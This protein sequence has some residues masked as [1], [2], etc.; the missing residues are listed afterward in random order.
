MEPGYGD[1]LRQTQGSQD[2]FD[3]IQKFID[4]HRSSAFPAFVMIFWLANGMPMPG[5][6][7]LIACIKTLP[8]INQGLVVWYRSLR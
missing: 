3:L 2:V 7:E 4:F 1:L 6:F 5:T 8:V